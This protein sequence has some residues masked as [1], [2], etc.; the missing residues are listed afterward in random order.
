MR[1]PQPAVA[2]V[3]RKQ[4]VIERIE[5]PVRPAGVDVNRQRRGINGDRDVSRNRRSSARIADSTHN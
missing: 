5:L 2:N 1:R 3:G 4:P